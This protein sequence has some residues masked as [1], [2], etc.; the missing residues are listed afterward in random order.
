MNNKIVFSVPLNQLG[1]LEN[2]SITIAG[3][4]VD[5]NTNQIVLPN[6][7]NEYKLTT[8]RGDRVYRTIKPMYR[9]AF[10]KEFCID[11]I[12]S[13]D[14]EEWKPIDEYCKYHIS[15]KGRIK[16]YQGRTAKLLKPYPNQYG[17][18]RVDINVKG[19]CCQ[20]VH[21]LVANAFLVNDNPLE[22]T[23]VDHIDGNK[24]NNDVNNLR[25]LSQADNIREYYKRIKGKQNDK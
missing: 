24:Q 12:V 1:F 19:R 17:Y 22:K 6:K 7:D 3:S 9:K 16:S 23:T 15:N 14:N 5:N 20:L 10:N 8:K 11:K 21:K 13:L 4:I 18:L 2:Y 25:F